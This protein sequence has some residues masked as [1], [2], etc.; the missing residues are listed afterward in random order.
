M[1]LISADTISKSAGGRILFNKISF[2]INEGDKI[3]LIGG[4]GCGKS[5]LLRILSG[6]EEIESGTIS[7]NNNCRISILKQKSQFNKN[8]TI[9]EH[10]LSDD[11][12][13]MN[14]VK[15]Y[16]LLV[17]SMAKNESDELHKI[18]CIWFGNVSVYEQH[19]RLA[20]GRRKS[21][22]SSSTC[23][24]SRKLPIQVVEE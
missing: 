8:D 20:E 17:D 6:E 3:A 11:S 18:V 12:P 21:G 14:T 10:I 24:P 23:S 5:T 22:R 2:G 15:E 1:N 19:G 13:L 4:N 9:L 16:E 7:R